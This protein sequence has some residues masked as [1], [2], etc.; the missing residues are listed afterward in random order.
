MNARLNIEEVTQRKE[1]ERALRESEER[2]SLAM[3]GANDGLWDWNFETDEVYYSPRWKS[4]L[5]YEEDELESN[6]STWSELVHPDDKDRILKKVQDYVAGGLTSFEAEMRMRHKD[7]HD[8][9][10]LSRAFLETRKE[11]DK[12]VRLVGTHVDITERKKAQVFDEKYAGILEMIATG[13]PASTIYDAIALMYEARHPGLRCSM[14]EL[15]GNVLLHGGAPSLPQEYCEAVNGLVNGPDIGSCGTATY[16]GKR[17]LVENIETDH[18]WADIKHVAL[19]HGMRCCWSE[20][21]KNSSGKVLGAFGM[22]YNYPTLPNDAELADLQSASRLAGIIMERVHNEIE[23]N[24]HRQ[25]LEELVEERTAEVKEKSARLEEALDKEKEYNVLQQ[26][27]VSLV[28]HEFR[29]PLTIIDGAA[30]RLIRRKH[31]LTPEEIE[32]RSESVRS[33]VKRLISLIDL[34]LHSS[35]IDAE[36]IEINPASCDVKSLVQEVCDR[37]AEIAPA[38]KIDVDIAALPDEISAD[39]NLLDMVFTNLLSNA[40]KYSPNAGLVQVGASAENGLATVWVSDNGIGIPK[41]ELP[42]MFKRFF[43]ARTAEGFG[44]TGIGLSISKEF[45]EMHGGTIDVQSEEGHGSTFRV[46]LPI[47]VQDQD[48]KAA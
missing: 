48:S 24:R 21:I 7:G 3:R 19:P 12:A 39:Q 13:Q 1:M 10:I 25:K 15:H 14:L 35:R 27:F 6:L 41:D 36:K 40:I 47:Q 22:Y 5:G 9:H 37:Q 8:V 2:F 32:G 11:D 23:L 33:A 43:R 20:P 17:V 44:G 26:K 16:T 30:Q 38:F 45:V 18:K 29:T 42:N 4:M 31:K 34:T 28:S 46:S